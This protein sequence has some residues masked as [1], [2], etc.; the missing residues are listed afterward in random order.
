V[1]VEFV[2]WIRGEERFDNAEA[3]ILRMEEDAQQA[4]ALL[5][6]AEAEQPES[7]IG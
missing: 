3:L 1:Q 7:M 6:R 2:G 4:Q 5:A